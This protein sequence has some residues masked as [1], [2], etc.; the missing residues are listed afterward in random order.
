MEK[1]SGKVSC[2][3][4]ALCS[5]LYLVLSDQWRMRRS[6]FVSWQG[7]T[8][9]GPY[10]C[11]HVIPFEFKDAPLRF[12]TVLQPGPQYETTHLVCLQR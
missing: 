4:R 11:L 8:L 7:N 2:A 10:V 1:D 5:L 9:E 3:Y 6:S 12:H